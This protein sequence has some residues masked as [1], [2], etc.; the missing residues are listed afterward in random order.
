MTSPCEESIFSKIDPNNTL[1]PKYILRISLGCSKDIL[2]SFGCSLEICAVKGLYYYLFFFRLYNFCLK[3]SFVKG[4]EK[5][6]NK[7]IKVT[8]PMYL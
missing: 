3:H 4:L 8:H 7:N 6:S 1:Y 2:M 5:N